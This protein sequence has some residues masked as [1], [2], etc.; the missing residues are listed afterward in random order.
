M[1]NTVIFLLCCSCN[2]IFS[3]QFLPVQHDTLEHK[4]EFFVHGVGDFS[5]SGLEKELYTKF[6]FG[7]EITDA[8]KWRSMD[9]QRGINRIGLDVSAEVEYRNYAVKGI[10]KNKWGFLVKGGYYNF[11]AA[12]YG[13][14]LFGLTFFGNEQYAGE[15]T[16]FSGTQFS[17][18]SFQKIGF[19]LIDKKSKSNIA[20][21]MY[22]VS[23]HFAGKLSDG[24]L[25]QSSNG[26][27]LFL[28]LDGYLE[29]TT[30]SQ[31]SNGFG[32]G[33]D[34]DFRFPVSLNSESV[35]FVQ[36]QAKNLGFFSVNNPLQT[37]AI[38]TT[39]AFDGFRFDALFDGVTNLENGADVLDSIG[40]VTGK[41]KG[42]RF[43]PG[44]LQAGKIIDEHSTK[45]IQGFFGVRMYLAVAY[46]PMLFA[47]IQ[48]KPAQKF[49]VGGTVRYG[50]FSN[51]N[52]GM[53]VQ[54]VGKKV[55]LGVA[56]ENAF[57]FITKRASGQSLVTR[58][59]WMF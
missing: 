39:I 42:Y 36:I 10:N 2:L 7:G 23:N 45:K 34:F 56:S 48:Y 58:L 8:I 33:V 53:Y 24:Q 32:F 12:L 54:Y 18:T 49:A 55:S 25:F 4:H 9:K 37:Y 47:G 17:A 19:G 50:G 11:A 1:R 26:D 21:N 31:R 30:G 14:D 52:I 35:S 46:S 44:F 59:R 5:T 15:N 16:N 57:G 28:T 27:S 6:V 29:H 22:S 38:D 40:V 51:T 41:S 43:L 3:Q 13:R 20:L